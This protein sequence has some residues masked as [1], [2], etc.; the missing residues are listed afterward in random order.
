M[1]RD[2][3]WFWEMAR[4]EVTVADQENQFARMRRRESARR[5]ADRLFA[6]R[7]REVA[8]CL[9]VPPRVVGLPRP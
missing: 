8:S 5:N 9:G 1:V 3:V 4:F 2:S 7:L 6:A